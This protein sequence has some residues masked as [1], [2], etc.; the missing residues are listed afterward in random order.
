MSLRL[1]ARFMRYAIDATTLVWL[2]RHDVTVDPAHQLV[3]PNSV[4][5]RALEILLSEVQQATLDERDA[6]QLHERLTAVKIRLLGDRVSRRVA[7]D[8]ARVHDWP[9]LRDAEYLA[10]ATLQADA[11]VTVD[12]ALAEKAQGLVP[13]AELRDLVGDDL[14]PGRRTAAP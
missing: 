13:L 11:L 7:W 12:P 4:R 10:V 9:D 8:L 6:L 14:T 5:T 2:V 3:A 1:Y